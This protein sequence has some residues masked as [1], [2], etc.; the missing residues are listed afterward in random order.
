MSR[1]KKNPERVILKSPDDDIWPNYGEYGDVH[2]LHVGN[3]LFTLDIT[4]MWAGC[5]SEVEFTV[6]GKPADTDDFGYHEDIDPKHKPPWAAGT[7]S[8]RC[9]R[10]V[11]KSLRSMV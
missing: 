5:Q 8:S 6:K 7:C 3:D 1:K 9:T 10:K 4:E 11:R 2:E